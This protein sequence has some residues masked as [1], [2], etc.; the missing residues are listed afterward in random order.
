MTHPCPVPDASLRWHRPGRIT[1]LMD[2]SAWPWH[3]EGS[4][5]TCP[6][7]TLPRS[8]LGYPKPGTNAPH[9]SGPHH[10]SPLP[11][12]RA[13]NLFR[14]RSRKRKPGMRGQATACLTLVSSPPSRPISGFVMSSRRCGGSA[15][16]CSTLCPREMA[17]LMQKGV[18]RKVVVPGRSLASAGAVEGLVMTEDCERMMRES[19]EIGE[20]T[21]GMLSG[22]HLAH[23]R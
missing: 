13:A 15:A 12:Y 23:A 8:L 11:V 22:T 19:S 7:T 4:R 18:V 9:S 14:D 10:R 20:D 6:C 3:A 21:R 17:E 1:P 2:S 5:R 16:A